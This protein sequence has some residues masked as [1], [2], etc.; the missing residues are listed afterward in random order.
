MS[1]KRWVHRRA[2]NELNVDGKSL[3]TF[4]NRPENLRQATPYKSWGST[5]WLN[6]LNF[7][8]N[9]DWL[10]L[11][12]IFSNPTSFEVP[13]KLDR[14]EV[15]V[16]RECLPC[17]KSLLQPKTVQQ[18]TSVQN[19]TIKRIHGRYV[20][21]HDNWTSEHTFVVLFTLCKAKGNKT[22]NTAVEKPRLI[23]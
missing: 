11:Y 14:K 3:K 13:F 22:A 5:S 18:Q 6:M 16:C 8:I 21:H 20:K 7:V 23:S 12:G 15:V 17:R 1:S 4:Y 10:R 2:S 9:R 19:A